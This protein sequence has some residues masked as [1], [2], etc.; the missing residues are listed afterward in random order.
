M[1]PKDLEDWMQRNEKTAID[2]ASMLKIHPVT[3]QRFLTGKRIQPIILQALKNMVSA[4][5]DA[6]AATG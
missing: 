4:G 2:I 1:R 5:S 3:V 6:K